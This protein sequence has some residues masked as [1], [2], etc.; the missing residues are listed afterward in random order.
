MA[1]AMRHVERAKLRGTAC[2]VPRGAK[3]LCAAHLDNPAHA[4]G[5]LR[6]QL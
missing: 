5:T 3:P 4:G 1:L 2:H 6:A